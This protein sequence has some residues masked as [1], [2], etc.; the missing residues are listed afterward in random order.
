[1]AMVT[2]TEA[3]RLAGTVRS[4]LYQA[5]IK[6]GILSVTKDS[7]GRPKVDTSELLRVFGELK[8]GQDTSTPLDTQQDGADKAGQDTGQQAVI[9]ILKQQLDEARVREQFYQQQIRE[10]TS[11]MKLLEHRP[12]PQT[13][14]HWW[15][16]WTSGGGWYFR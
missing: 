14:R 16:F 15:K 2:I 7:K 3:A 9:D 8:A 4:N 1:M 10:F 6:T 11:T 5:Y 13:H 12:Q